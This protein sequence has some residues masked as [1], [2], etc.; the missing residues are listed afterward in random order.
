VQKSGPVEKYNEALCTLPLNLP[1]DVITFS[2]PI[3]AHHITTYCNKIFN[4]T[5]EIETLLCLR[6]P[7]VSKKKITTTTDPRNNSW[8]VMCRCW[9][10]LKSITDYKTVFTNK[11]SIMVLMPFTIN[12]KILYTI[13]KINFWSP[14]TFYMRTLYAGKGTLFLWECWW[15]CA[16]TQ[17]I[18]VSR[19]QFTVFIYITH[20]TA[21]CLNPHNLSNLESHIARQLCYKHTF[22]QNV[23]TKI[24]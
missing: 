14:K 24:W 3:R 19:K 1:P 20:E 6:Y 17:E 4:T 10:C 7:S 18:F 23:H 5:F 9:S 11:N 13:K 15:D 8:Q 12:G 21:I 16:L 22:C 2:L